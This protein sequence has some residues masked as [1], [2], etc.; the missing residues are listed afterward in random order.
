MFSLITVCLELILPPAVSTGHWNIP[1]S[2]RLRVPDFWSWSGSHAVSSC[3]F[4]FFS[5]IGIPLIDQRSQTLWRDC[6]TIWVTR[7]QAW[8]RFPP[9]WEPS[10]EVVFWPRFDMALWSSKKKKTLKWL[11]E[12]IEKPIMLNKRRRWFYSSREKLPLVRTAASWFLVSTNLIWILG[13]NFILSNSQSR[14]TLWVLETCLIVG[15]RPSII[16]LM[17]ASVSTK[18]YNWDSPWE[19]ECVCLWKH[20]PHQRVDQPYAFF[21]HFG[22]WFWNGQSHQFPGCQ[23]G[24]VGQCCWFNVVPQSPCAKDQEQVTIHT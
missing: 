23:Y 12:Y 16:I 6:F 2:T 18:K 20:N 8:S 15:L 3:Y 14:A 1:L 13:S 10:F 21:W 5:F 24:W 11:Q 17:T 4:Y 19:E 9:S 22:S 7:H